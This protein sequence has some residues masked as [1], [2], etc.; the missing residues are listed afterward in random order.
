LQGFEGGHAQPHPSGTWTGHRG[1]GCWC[2][3]LSVLAYTYSFN[4]NHK[5]V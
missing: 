4:E 2:K 1:T 5:T 3:F